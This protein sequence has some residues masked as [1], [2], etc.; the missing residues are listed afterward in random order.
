L[1]QELDKPEKALLE[2]LNRGDPASREYGDHAA[3]VMVEIVRSVAKRNDVVGH[4]LLINCLPRWAIHPGTAQTVLIASGPMA[5]QLT[6]L[7]LPSDQDDPVKRGPRYVCHAPA[8]S[9]NRAGSIV[10]ATAATRAARMR[11]NRSARAALG[12]TSPATQQSRPTP[13]ESATR[14][15]PIGPAG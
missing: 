6:F 13:P 10:R 3:Q 2:E 14:S 9:R 12:H 7:H 11:S 5:E 1:G 15:T 4:G 8:V